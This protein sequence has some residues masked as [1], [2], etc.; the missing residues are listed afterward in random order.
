MFIRN[1]AD[2]RPDF[3]EDTKWDDRVNWFVLDEIFIGLVRSAFTFLLDLLRSVFDVICIDNFEFDCEEQKVEAD[4]WGP[5]KRIIEWRIYN[6][7][8]RHREENEKWFTD[9]EKLYGLKPAQFI[10][11]YLESQKNRSEAPV[12]ILQIYPGIFLS[13]IFNSKQDI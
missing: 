1:V 2:L 5:L 9:F 6:V 8:E 12:I 13:K 3:K 10:A 4:A 7:D 11:S